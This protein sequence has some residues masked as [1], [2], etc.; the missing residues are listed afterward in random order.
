MTPTL[1]AL[2][3]QWSSFYA[4]DPYLVAAVIQ[5]E[6]SWDASMTGAAGEIGL[7]QVMPTTAGK[8]PKKLKSNNI[9][10]YHGVKY[11]RQAKDTCKHQDKDMFVVCYNRGIAGGSKLRRPHQD[12]YYNKVA[13]AKQALLKEGYFA[14]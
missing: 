4:M 12:A 5:T 7:M 3:M 1:M 9:N 6:S 2:I 13:A 8:P 10:I 14:R 11:L